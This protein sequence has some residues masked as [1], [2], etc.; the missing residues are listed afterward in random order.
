MWAMNCQTLKNFRLMNYLRLL[1]KKILPCKTEFQWMLSPERI[2]LN[3][4][5]RVFPKGGLDAL[6][7]LS[8][9]LLQE[10]KILKFKNAQSY[11]HQVSL[12][13]EVDAVSGSS[14]IWASVLLSTAAMSLPEKLVFKC[15]LSQVH[16][17]L[18]HIIWMALCG[19]QVRS[20]HVTFAL[21]QS[22]NW[23]F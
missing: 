21:E 11:L 16:E 14:C 19:R 9:F 12:L 18:T 2:N 15:K 3:G 13:A 17:W 6:W 8:F 4:D 22:S 1:V 5:L 7:T 23:F 20:L 10:G